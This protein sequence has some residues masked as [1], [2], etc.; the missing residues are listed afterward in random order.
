M[1]TS[2]IQVQKYLK[3]IDYPVDKK[4]IVQVA[5]SQGADEN[6]IRTLQS[7]PDRTYD[8]PNAISKELGRS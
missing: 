2:P 3:G 5:R 7:I 6:V 1:T 8:G 4:K